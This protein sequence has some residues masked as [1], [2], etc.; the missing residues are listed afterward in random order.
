MFRLKG[1]T[2]RDR[3]C[4]YRK[5]MGLFTSGACNSS[6][7]P[8]PR[9]QLQDRVVSGQGRWN[10]EESTK[11]CVQSSVYIFPFAFL[12]SSRF[13]LLYII[14]QTFHYCHR[15]YDVFVPRLTCS[16]FFASPPHTVPCHLSSRNIYHG[17]VTHRFQGPSSDHS[18]LCNDARWCRPSRF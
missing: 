9:P 8:V 3:E 12:G 17:L 1:L 15:K 11:F 4:L 2:L 7:R 13:L 6:W 10:K 16:F 5:V 14:S 18:S